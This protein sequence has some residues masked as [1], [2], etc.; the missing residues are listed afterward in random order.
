[1]IR[2]EKIYFVECDKCGCY[3]VHTCNR[4]NIRFSSVK[5]AEKNAEQQNWTIKDDEHYCP[6]CQEELEQERVY[7]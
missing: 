1:M 3:V 5:E 4:E 2:E 7:D 6:A